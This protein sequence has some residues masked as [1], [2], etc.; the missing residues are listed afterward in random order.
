MKV[1]NSSRRVITAAEAAGE[2]DGG[3][4][5]LNRGQLAAL[6]ERHLQ[7]SE[8]IVQVLADGP[9]PEVGI[10]VVVPELIGNLNRDAPIESISERAAEAKSGRRPPPSITRAV[11]SRSAPIADS[12]DK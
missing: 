6:F 2:I 7:L 10:G 8:R 4:P 1:S 12:S 11:I 9:E 3:S 5:K